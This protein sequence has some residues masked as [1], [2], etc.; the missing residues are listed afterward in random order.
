MWRPLENT[1][2]LLLLLSL[3]FPGAYTLGFGELENATRIQSSGKAIYPPKIGRFAYSV[4]FVNIP[5]LSIV[6]N[7]DCCSCFPAFQENVEDVKA[8]R[9]DFQMLLYWNIRA[10]GNDRP[11]FPL[12]ENNGWLAKDSQGRYL[13]AREWQYMHMIDVG[14]GDYQNWLAHRLGDDVSQYGYDGVFL[15]YGLSTRMTGFYWNVIAE[16][17]QQQS[18]PVNPRTGQ[19]F[20]DSEIRQALTSLNQKIR[21]SI[22]SGKLQICNG[23]WDGTRYHNRESEYLEILKAVDL[24]GIMAEGLWH[25]VTNQWITAEEWLQ[26]VELLKTFPR[27]IIATAKMDT[28]PSGCSKQQMATFAYTSTLLGIPDHGCYLRLYDIWNANDL[29][30]MKDLVANL[31]SIPIGEPV[32]DYYAIEGTPVYCREFT[33]ATVY[34]N[35]TDAQYTIDGLDIQ[36]HAG[37]IVTKEG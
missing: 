3:V 11:E 16:G 34:V 29:D 17:T 31:N 25:H 15:D 7:F 23:V 6:E 12:F 32:G 1:L 9:P 18:Y 36:P 35:P 5:L 24:E 10:I 13:V 21:T 20:T 37:R 2:T 4:R 27:Q 28:L 33:D 8:L 30:E 19:E 22:G 26:S 14:N